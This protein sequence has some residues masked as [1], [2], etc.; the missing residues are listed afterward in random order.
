MHGF[1]LEPVLNR[2][3]E[4]GYVRLIKAPANKRF[5]GAGLTL[6][7]QLQVSTRSMGPAVGA[8]SE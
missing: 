1:F 4:D 2:F 8:E 3:V 7:A 5:Q 6:A